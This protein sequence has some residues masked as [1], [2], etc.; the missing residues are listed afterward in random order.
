MKRMNYRG[1]RFGYTRD[2]EDYKSR[3]KDFSNKNV[4]NNVSCLLSPINM[5][6]IEKKNLYQKQINSFYTPI[7]NDDK[8]FRNN[9]AIINPKQVN[10]IGE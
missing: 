2:D 8:V 9:S 10:Y 6:N 3:G 7:N 1:N 5:K 4:L